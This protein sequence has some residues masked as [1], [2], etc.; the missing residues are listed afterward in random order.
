VLS[1]EEKFQVRA[2]VM[3]V[4]ERSS[5]NFRQASEMYRYSLAFL[6]LSTHGAPDSEVHLLPRP[7]TEMRSSIISS[8]LSTGMCAADVQKWSDGIQSK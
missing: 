3:G 8:T 7:T 5:S 1:L 4:M 6:R 2:R